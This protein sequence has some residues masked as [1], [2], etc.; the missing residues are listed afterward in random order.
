MY[1]AKERE[2]VLPGQVIATKEKYDYLTCEVDGENVV[3]LTQGLF[4]LGKYGAEI[5]PLA[6]VYRPKSEDV[7]IG[8]I[9]SVGNSSWGV[10]I[11]VPYNCQ[12]PADEVTRDVAGVDLTRFYK[13]GDIISGIVRS[14]NELHET[15]LTRPWKLQGGRII[16]VEPVKVPRI[17][18]KKRSMLTVLKEKTGSKIIVGQNG[19]V[20][21][22]GEQT[23]LV[24]E[25]IEKIQKE[26]HTQ[27]LTDR[28]A[29]MLDEKTRKH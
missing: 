12:L 8:V 17:I 21:I 26:A 3:A 11:K 29:H 25:A 4:H 1:H 27:G 24:I 9:T 18:G 19:L 22:S 5:V 14:V 13:V 15:T 20:W 2:V 28:I 10:D 16:E 7:V 6:G 23:P